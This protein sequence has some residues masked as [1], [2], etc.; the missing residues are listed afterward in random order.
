MCWLNQFKLW[1]TDWSVGGSSSTKP[2]PVWFLGKAF[3]PQLNLV[4][5][6]PFV[7]LG[8]KMWEI[9]HDLVKGEKPTLFE[10]FLNF[11][12]SAASGYSQHSPSRHTC[13]PKTQLG[14]KKIKD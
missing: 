10:S 7:E 1:V 8:G 5:L 9:K 13:T 11:F 4:R 6:N 2:A 3:N 14:K 12:G